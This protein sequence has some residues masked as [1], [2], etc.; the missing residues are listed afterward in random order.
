MSVQELKTW[1]FMCDKCNFT[2]CEKA[3]VQPESARGWMLVVRM[4]EAYRTF[5]KVERQ[6]HFCAG[7][8]NK[9]GLNE[10]KDSLEQYDRPDQCYVVRE[11]LD[12]LAQKKGEG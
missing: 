9:Y 8:R 7:C 3:V 11:V 10:C 2:A 6:Y 4:E 1:M 12:I 5:P